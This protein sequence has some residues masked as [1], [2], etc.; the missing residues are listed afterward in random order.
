MSAPSIAHQSDGAE[1]IADFER[2]AIAI[3]GLVLLAVLGYLALVAWRLPIDY[4]DG[5]EYLNNA[6]VLA[7]HASAQLPIEYSHVRPPMI[8]WLLRP[9]MAFYAP[10]GEGAYPLTHLLMWAIAVVSLWQLFRLFRRTLSPGWALG[11]IALLA[12]N[13]AFN[14]QVPFVM[15]DILSML[16]SILAL[17]AVLA[18]PRHAW[19]GVVALAAAFAFSILSKYPMGLLFPLLG[20]AVLLPEKNGPPWRGRIPA[21]LRYAASAV[22]AGAF[23]YLAHVVLFGTL[24][25]DWALAWT[26]AFDGALEAF[27]VGG[28][29]QS[30]DPRY[31]YLA[32]YWV[33]LTPP[34]FLVSF[35]GLGAGLVRR[36][37]EDLAH[38]VWAVGFMLALSLWVPHKEMRYALPALPSWLYFVVLG[39]Q[40]LYAEL[41]KR[42]GE[43]LPKM[44]VPGLL[45]IACAMSVNLGADELSR[46]EDDLY[47]LPTLANMS[48]HVETLG[49]DTELI[50]SAGQLPVF[51]YTLYPADPVLLPLD[52]YWHFHHINSVAL[53]WYLGRLPLHLQV[54]PS[55]MGKRVEKKQGI[56]TL[57]LPSDMLPIADVR[58]QWLE[59]FDD[60]GVVLSTPQKYYTALSAARLPEPPASLQVHRIE[61]RTFE[62]ETGEG[63]SPATYREL[64]Q[65]EKALSLT[66]TEGKWVPSQAPARWFAYG[67]QVPT[68]AARAWD[69][70]QTPP[71]VL[72]WV[73]MSG[74]GFRA[75]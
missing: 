20:L 58:L 11:G 64:K 61:R 3:I 15:A 69:E 50:A 66:L 56:V 41:K 54:Q 26:H 73:R 24:K 52:E 43:R 44:A 18:Q 67:R 38:A 39:L 75:R 1:N 68:G 29:A 8:A 7:G 72:E 21:A 71:P 63:I 19:L 34:L 2:R 6:R 53:S 59:L 17:R 51:V 45:T 30:S 16:G 4:W 35:V 62:R 33:L 37:R 60:T 9:A 23:I 47:R 25:H 10:H 42:T 14:S 28:S 22:I 46:F 48:R 57:L 31:E 70:S 32:A 49:P 5:Y 55:A 36:T 65:R 40:T 74:V 12:L 13:P 27:R